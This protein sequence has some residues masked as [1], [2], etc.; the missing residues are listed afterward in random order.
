[1]REKKQKPENAKKKSPSHIDTTT[2]N[3][4]AERQTYNFCSLSVPADALF[5]KFFSYHCCNRMNTKKTE[6]LNEKLIGDSI[7]AHDD[8]DK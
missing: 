3:V 5:L 2:Q 4:C 7:C 6:L 1:M 8:C